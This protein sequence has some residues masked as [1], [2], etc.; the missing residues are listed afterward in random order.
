MRAQVQQGSDLP[1]LLV[2]PSSLPYTTCTTATPAA[3]SVTVKTGPS[4]VGMIDERKTR[5]SGSQEIL[6]SW[7]GQRNTRHKMRRLALGLSSSASCKTSNEDSVDQGKLSG[8][9][10][11]ER[12]LCL[13][14]HS[15]L[16]T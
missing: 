13:D 3:K 2:R 7:H 6:D 8:P 1:T 12:M 15:Q 9:C 4:T 16:P 5:T 11:G 14:P 10:G